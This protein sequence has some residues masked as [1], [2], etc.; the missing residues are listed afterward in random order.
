MPHASAPLICLGETLF[1]AHEVSCP[2]ILPQAVTDL[3]DVAV[4]GEKIIVLRRS[5]PQLVCFD[6]EGRYESSCSLPMVVLGHGLRSLPGNRLALT[7]LDG[8]KVLILDASLS[9]ILTLSPD[10]LPRHLSPFNHPTDCT[11]SNDGV[12]YVADGYGN[13]RVHMF[14]DEGRHL[15]SFGDAGSGPG[16]FST[17]HS[18]LIDHQNRVCVA[19]REN[20]RVQRFDLGGRF[21]DEIGGLYKPMALGLRADGALLVTDQTPRLSVYSPDRDL[22]G[23][24]RTFGTY[25]HGIAHLANADIVLSEMLPPRLRILKALSHQSE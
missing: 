8:H 16:Q 2:Q 5:T 3:S 6:L 9:V 20:N 10:G 11:Q 24:C 22:L 25:G 4:L 21:L 13:S 7:D 19:D 23:R 1:A 12:F 15:D 18:V 17:P 14:D